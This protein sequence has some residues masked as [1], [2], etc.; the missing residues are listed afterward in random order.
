MTRDPDQSAA[1]LRRAFDA[2]FAVPPPPRADDRERL[3]LLRLGA[4]GYAFRLAEVAG[5]VAARKIVALGSSA[6]GALGV[7]GIRGSLVPVYS[8][9]ALVG[10][11]TVDD[12]PPRWFVLSG[13]PEPFALAFARFDGYLELAPAELRA[14]AGLLSVAALRDTIT[15]SAAGGPAHGKSKEQ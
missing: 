14:R 1:G 3:L 4:D 10:C 8:L 12:A 6:A 11:A 2:S 5:F 7:A 13:A 9:A 15:T